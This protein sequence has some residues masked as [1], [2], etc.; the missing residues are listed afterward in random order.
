MKAITRTILV[1]AAALLVH[2]LPVAADD[3]T[4]V[5]GGQTMEQG[6]TGQKDECLLVAKNC[7]NDVDSIQERIQRIQGELAKGID[8]YSF[9]ELKQLTNELEE[10]RNLLDYMLTNGGA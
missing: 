10:Y 7:G 5:P 8:V 9:D 1:L 3:I 2:V 4:A 6:V